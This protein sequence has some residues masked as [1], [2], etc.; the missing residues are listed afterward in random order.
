MTDALPPKWAVTTVG[1][2][3]RAVSKAGPC[4]D[5]PTFRYIDLSSVDNT[6]KSITATAELPVVSAPSRAKQI[7]KLGDVLFSNVRVYLENIALVPSNL[8]GEIASTAFCVLR[9]ADGVEPRYLYHFATSRRFI[10][11][12]NALQRGNSPPSVQDG[13][14]QAQSFPLAPYKEQQRIASRVDEL[15]SRIE[16]GERALTRVQ[17]LVERYRQS[18]LKAAVTGELTRDWRKRQHAKGGQPVESGEALLHSILAARRAAWE[19]SE[20]AKMQAKGI[21]PKDDAWKKKYKEPA[22]ADT[23]GLPDLPEGW[24]W[25]TLEHICECLDYVRVPV[26]AK[27]RQARRGNVPYYGANGQVGTIDAHLFDEPLVL[28]VEDE[29]FTGRTKPFSYKIDGKSWVNN[30]AHVLRPT[31]AVDVDFLN[32][33]LMRYPFIPLTTGTTARRKLTQK[34]LMSAPVAMPA[35]TEQ[36]K[37]LSAAGHLLGAMGCVAC[38]AVQS[39]NAA[40]AL[41]QAV[42]RSAFAGELVPQDPADEPAS[43]L[44]TRIATERAAAEPS[45]KR[46]RRKQFA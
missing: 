5:K 43:V 27:G 3:C 17:K 12:V 15:F 42:L 25:V 31:S 32:L 30:H 45:R 20:L 13:D 16:E 21:K 41:K 24:A 38:G 22:P 19:Q 2:V 14:V 9:P 44:L 39:R 4:P 35:T 29:T 40:S 1:D 8:D 26:S 33:V 7:V 34:A 28:V 11:D 10:R 37:I 46:R 36:K 23:V 6:A 18:V